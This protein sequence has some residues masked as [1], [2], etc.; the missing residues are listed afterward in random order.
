MLYLGAFAPILIHIDLI[1]ML[2]T[3]FLL[4]TVLGLKKVTLNRL[5]VVSDLRE[6][7]G[8]R[9]VQLTIPKSSMI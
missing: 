8:K 6:L 1:S 9:K 3:Y 7:I 2:K 5:Y 4:S